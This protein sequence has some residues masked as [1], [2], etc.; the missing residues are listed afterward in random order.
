MAI[1]YNLYRFGMDEGAVGHLI[2]GDFPDDEDE[3]WQV[4]DAPRYRIEKLLHDHTLAQ[5]TLRQCRDSGQPFVLFLRSF[6]SE[7]TPQREG[8]VFGGMMTTH[9]QKLQEFLA[10]FSLAERSVPIVKLFGGFDAILPG[11][12]FP[13]APDTGV[14]SAHAD[15]WLDVVAEL[16]SAASAIVF[17]VSDLSEGVRQEIEQI[18]R[19]NAR[20]RSL[21]VLMD[22]KKTFAAGEEVDMDA[23]SAAFDGFP[24][25]FELE[26]DRNS[27]RRSTMSDEFRSSLEHLLEENRLAPELDKSITAGFSYLD[28]EYFESSDYTETEEFLWRELRRL[29]TLFHDRYWAELK[30]RGVSYRELRFSHEWLPAH[31]AYGLAIATADFVAIQEALTALE[32]L[33]TVRG[34]LY[35]FN[36]QALKHQYRE[37]ANKCLPLGIRDTESR[38]TD[39][40]DPL[41]IEPSQAAALKFFEYAETSAGNRNFDIANYLYQVAVNIALNCDGCEETENR[42]QLSRMTHDWAKFQAS[43][44]LSNWAVVNYEYSLSLSRELAEQDPERYLPE[45]ALCLNNLGAL[46]FRMDNLAACE[47]AFQ[48]AVD[49]RR[50]RPAESEKYHEDLGLSL[51]NLGM[52][53]AARS[54]FPSARAHYEDSIAVTRERLENEPAAILDLARCQLFLAQCLAKTPNAPSDLTDAVDAAMA[55]LPQLREHDAVAAAQFEEELQKVSALE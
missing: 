25:V 53:T 28:P 13:G 4:I 38:Y 51:L 42:W 32:L 15:N 24:N 17:L 47:A 52:V 50:G 6:S 30:A 39:H 41:T 55:I 54:D 35:S 26:P 7:C 49:I 43:T 22:P 44:N 5:D 27:P 2:N 19:R 40:K 46:Q 34:S 1:H 18:H 9:S 16:V 10:F 12:S 36:L 14:L 11:A 23:L 8:S 31:R 48:E 37:L 21:V 3:R 33:Y 29:R 20:A 45:I